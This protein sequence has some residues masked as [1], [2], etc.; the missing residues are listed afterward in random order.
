MFTFTRERAILGGT[1]ATLL[2]I[3]CVL[4]AIDNPGAFTSA[5]GAINLICLLSFITINFIAAIV[6]GGEKE[7]THRREPAREVAPSHPSWFF[8][9]WE[10]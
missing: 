6:G 9:T 10:Q 1:V 8:S 4:A 3:Q 5:I 2:G 7:S